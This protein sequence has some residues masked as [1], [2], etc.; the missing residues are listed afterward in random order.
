MIN[1]NTDAS[2]PAEILQA[3][4]EEYR[5]PGYPPMTQREIVAV[6]GKTFEAYVGRYQKS[7]AD[8]VTIWRVGNRLFAKD[9]SDHRAEL[10]PSSRSDFF[11]NVAPIS[12]TFVKDDTGTVVNMVTHQAGQDIP[13]KRID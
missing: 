3:I 9:T 4:A 5:W 12:V 2:F 7:E 10:F 1:A 6:D 11:V 13:G 8:I